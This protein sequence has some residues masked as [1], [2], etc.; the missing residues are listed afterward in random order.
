MSF[1]TA[2]ERK[3]VAMEEKLTPSWQQFVEAVNKFKD[4]YAIVGHA[5]EK[6]VGFF[7][8]LRPHLDYSVTGRE[9]ETMTESEFLEELREKPLVLLVECMDKRG[10]RLTQEKVLNEVMPENGFDPEKVKLMTLAMGGGVIQRDIITTEQGEEKTVDRGKAFETILEYIAAQAQVSLVVATGHN[11][12]CG[13]E[14][15]AAG[16]KGWPE[17]LEVDPGDE[18]ENQKMKELIKLQAAQHLPQ[19]WQD[20]GLV[21]LYLVRFSPRPEKDKQVSLEAI[22]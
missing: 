22:V 1:P 11:H 10:A 17:R 6:R 12:R 8:E 5:G 18:V 13:A 21:K 14:A 15:F 2:R 3:G 7:G 20:Q 4:D 9:V 16:G 19:Q